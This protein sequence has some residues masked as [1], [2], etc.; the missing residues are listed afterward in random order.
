MSVESFLRQTMEDAGVPAKIIDKAMPETLQNFAHHMAK[1]G[2]PAAELEYMEQVKNLGTEGYR[3]V[4]EMSAQQKEEIKMEHAHAKRT[5]RRVMRD[6]GL[7]QDEIDAHLPAATQLFVAQLAQRRSAADAEKLLT[8]CPRTEEIKRTTKEIEQV[9]DKKHA[10]EPA[11][12]A[13]ALKRAAEAVLES[14]PNIQRLLRE[15][16]IDSNSLNENGKLMI[17][18]VNSFQRGLMETLGLDEESN[19]LGAENQEV[20]HFAFTAFLIRNHS[21]AEPVPATESTVSVAVRLA[22][23]SDIVVSAAKKGALTTAMVRDSVSAILRQTDDDWWPDADEVFRAAAAMMNERLAGARKIG[24]MSDAF[25]RALGL[26]TDDPFIVSAAI[27]GALTEEMVRDSVAAILRQTDGGCQL[28]K[29]D[30]SDWFISEHTK[31]MNERGLRTPIPD[32]CREHGEVWESVMYCSEMQMQYESFH[33]NPD[34]SGS[35]YVLTLLDKLDAAAPARQQPPPES[36]TGWRHASVDDYGRAMREALEELAESDRAKVK[37]SRVAYD[38]AMQKTLA[39]MNE[40]F[41]DEKHQMTFAD[42]EAQIRAIGYA[43][44]RGELLPDP[45]AVHARA[46]A[47]SGLP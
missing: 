21:P 9:R 12:S 35:L 14:N 45:E 2:R 32:T 46:R 24:Q 3:R 6:A 25:Q 19:L 37:R 11:I 33:Q 27:K 34:L 23:E 47:R 15:N 40:T 36:E 38:V 30:G 31:M 5:M 16:V 29:E 20:V 1:V 43:T 13:E 26:V 10:A 44:R 17:D 41:G 7:P 22:M 18:L 28:E 42:L 8:P 39:Y 4:G